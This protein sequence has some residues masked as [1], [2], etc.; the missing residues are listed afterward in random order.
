MASPSGVQVVQHS[1]SWLH[2]GMCP[3]GQSSLCLQFEKERQ[4]STSA[5]ISAACRLGGF[6]YNPQ[7]EDR[8]AEKKFCVLSGWRIYEKNK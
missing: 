4:V 8:V 3:G 1:H 7:E 6:L 5:F 2:G